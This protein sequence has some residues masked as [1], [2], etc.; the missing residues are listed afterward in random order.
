MTVRAVGAK[1]PRIA[2]SSWISE[3]AYVVGDVEVG[4]DSSI[5]PGAVVRAD[6]APVVIGANTHIEDNCVIHTGIPLTVGDDVLV[7]HGAVLHCSRVGRACLIGNHATVL[8][9]AVL[10]DYTLVAAG[11][12][13]LGGTVVP[14]ESFVSGVPATVRP[15]TPGQLA[16][17]RAQQSRD[18]GYGPLLREYRAAGL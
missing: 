2:P 3:A 11:A 12:V 1:V 15:I 7:G 6:L 4:P 9:G 10:G 16:R 8:D 18:A 13:L 5:W 14:Q 17:L